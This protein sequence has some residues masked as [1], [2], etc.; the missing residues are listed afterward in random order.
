MIGNVNTLRERR[1]LSLKHDEN[2]INALL[3]FDELS[4][5]INTMNIVDT[6]LHI[7]VER[8]LPSKIDF[9]E[10]GKKSDAYKF[11]EGSSGVDLDAYFAK[12]ILHN[13][14]E[15]SSDVCSVDYEKASYSE[16]NSIFYECHEKR[17][18]RIYKTSTREFLYLASLKHS[19]FVTQK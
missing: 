18:S 8:L 5:E 19:F 2:V 17:I 3:H 10:E 15:S 13:E 12:L 4:T 7:E 14:Q 11:E 9:T 16:D 1:G 6:Y